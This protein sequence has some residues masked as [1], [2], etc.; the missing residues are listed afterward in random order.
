MKQSLPK[1]ISHSKTASQR[2]YGRC[3]TPSFHSSLGYGSTSS[4][5]TSPSRALLTGACGSSMGL[6][7][8]R[9]TKNG[10]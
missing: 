5:P 3:E 6:S 8:S 1:G 7:L 9:R 10:K 2:S 4:K